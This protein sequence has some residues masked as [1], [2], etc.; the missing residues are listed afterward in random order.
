[1]RVAVTGSTGFVGSNIAEVLTTAGHDVIGLVR[2]QPE[3]KLVWGHRLVDFV[4]VESLSSAISGFDAV[5]HCAIANDFNRL[6]VDRDYAYDSYVG[7]TQ[8]LVAAS[9][10]AD[11]HFVYISTDWIMDGTEHQVPETNFGNPINYYGYLKALSEQVVRDLAPNNGAVCRIAGVM[12]QHRAADQAPRS[13]DVGFGYFVDSIVRTLRAG[14]PFTV[15]GGDFVNKVTSPSL[16][17][18]IGAQV[19][20]VISRKATGTFH[21][22]ADDAI[23]RMPLA[24]LVCDVFDLDATMLREAEPPAE[25][26][27]PAPIPVD[28]SLGNR[29]TKLALGLGPTPLR[30]LLEAF[31]VELDTGVISPLTKPEE[32]N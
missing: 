21:L 12:G 4:D 24:Q 31:R 29:A 2:R 11:A 13:Q 16:A 28:S 26:R 10:R 19:E 7:M 5:V 17:A 14:K 23:G 6:L 15:Y 32:H 3:R 18:E 25:E 30:A 8:R 20:R 27:F 1:L 9:N 22:V